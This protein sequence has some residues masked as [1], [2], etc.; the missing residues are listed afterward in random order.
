[1]SDIRLPRKAEPTLAEDLVTFAPPSS[2]PADKDQDQDQ[3][4]NMPHHP[5]FS[6][7]LLRI[8][9]SMSMH[10]Q[11]GRPRLPEQQIIARFLEP[12]NNPWAPEFSF[13][14]FLNDIEI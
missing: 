7:Q 5:D 12:Q 1:M 11:Q 14:Q 4:E 2:P 8:I 3:D 6:Q 10:L 9:M 13:E